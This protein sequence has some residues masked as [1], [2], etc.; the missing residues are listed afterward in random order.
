MH[1]EVCKVYCL[2][3][4]SGMFVHVYTLVHVCVV[5]VHS[6]CVCMFSNAPT[7]TLVYFKHKCPTYIIIM[8]NSIDLFVGLI[9]H[10]SYY[11]VHITGIAVS[12]PHSM[13]IPK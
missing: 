1:I 10:T 8:P 3:K 6:Q 13:F 11:I 12:A 2:Q 9:T 7:V 4:Y 5:C